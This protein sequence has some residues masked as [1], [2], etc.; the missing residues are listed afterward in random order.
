M[1]DRAEGKHWDCGDDEEA[2]LVEHVKC[3]EGFLVAGRGNGHVSIYA[4]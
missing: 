4:C 2:S 1:Y 3:K